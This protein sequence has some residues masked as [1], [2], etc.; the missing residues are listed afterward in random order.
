MY[1]FGF[2]KLFNVFPSLPWRRC[3]LK[4]LIIYKVSSLKLINLFAPVQSHIPWF[5][6][7][8]H[9]CI[10]HYHAY[11]FTT[12][13]NTSIRQGYAGGYA[14]SRGFSLAWL[15]TF[16]TSIKWLVS[17]VVGLFYTPWIKQ[18]SY[19]RDWQVMRTTSW[20][21]KTMQHERQLCQQGKTRTWPPCLLSH[22]RFNQVNTARFFG[23]WAVLAKDKH[24]LVAQSM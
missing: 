6:F 4:S 3:I 24:K 10:Q 13:T 7:S 12:I 23:S 20:T 21:L 16:T 5:F 19:A 14:M 22:Q 18:T 9:R 8:S 17:R 15:L 11:F 1:L 2:L